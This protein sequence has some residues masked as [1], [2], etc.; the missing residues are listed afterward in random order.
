VSDTPKL[1]EA[2]DS[3]LRLTPYSALRVVVILTKLGKPVSVG[4]THLDAWGKLH[5]DWKPEKTRRYYRSEYG[6]RA[7]VFHSQNAEHIR[8]DG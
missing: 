3:G 6:H 1:A 8:D 5:Q 2:A 4:K 7:V